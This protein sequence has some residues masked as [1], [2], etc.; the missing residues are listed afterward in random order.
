MPLHL[1]T[2]RITVK[3]VSDPM[4]ISVMFCCHMYFK[5]DKTFA[6]YSQMKH[7]LNLHLRYIKLIELLGF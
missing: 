2:L 1:K 4:T 5:F 6:L 3:L 7:N